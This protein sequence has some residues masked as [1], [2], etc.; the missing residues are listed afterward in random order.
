[1]RD[2]IIKALRSLYKINAIFFE[3]YDE[4]TSYRCDLQENCGADF[5]CVLDN[6][7][8]FFNDGDIYQGDANL[9]VDH[10]NRE[11]SL[12]FSLHSGYRIKIK[13]EP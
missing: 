2:G 12:H 7:L 4:R 6:D 11:S 8:C 1:M 3:S 9:I 10:L 13:E 5:Y